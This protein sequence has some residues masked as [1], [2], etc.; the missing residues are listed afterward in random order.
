MEAH[1][2]VTSDN[3]GVVGVFGTESFDFLGQVGQDSIATIVGDITSPHDYRAQ[4]GAAKKAYKKPVRRRPAD[5]VACIIRLDEEGKPSGVGY[6][7][8][9]CLEAGL[10]RDAE[11]KVAFTKK[12]FLETKD[13]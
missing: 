1:V 9:H 10:A 8:A 13:R 2:P 4:E 6:T 3:K 7:I 12:R 11:G 5:R